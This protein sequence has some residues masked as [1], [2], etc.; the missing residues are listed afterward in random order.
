[1]NHFCLLEKGDWTPV[2][3]GCFRFLGKNRTVKKNFF[4]MPKSV[5]PF[6]NKQYTRHFKS[7]Y[8][9]FYF[10]FVCSYLSFV[11]KF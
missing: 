6:D 8:I 11:A 4:D 3:L 5:Y 10:D 7:V 2:F 1:M 9:L